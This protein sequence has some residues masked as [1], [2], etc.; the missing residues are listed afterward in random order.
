MEHEC[1]VASSICGAVSVISQTCSR[2]EQQVL[3]LAQHD[4]S[5]IVISI[6]PICQDLNLTF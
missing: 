2:S 4:Y 5:Y 1:P 3:E 6:I